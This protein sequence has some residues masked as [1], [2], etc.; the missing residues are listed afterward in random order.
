MKRKSLLAATLAGSLLGLAGFAQAAPA[1]VYSGTAYGNPGV[2]VQMAPPA[3][4]YEALPA[5]RSGYVW[6]PGHYVWNNGAYM[7]R[8]GEWMTARPGYSWQQ[9]QWQQRADGSWFLASGAWIPANT[10]SRADRDGDGI[11]NRYDADRDGDGIVNWNDRRP[12]N[13]YR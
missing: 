5:H 3:P 7:W 13:Y 6:A 12:N 10:A 11:R 8:G 9:A 2:I 4:I 1:V